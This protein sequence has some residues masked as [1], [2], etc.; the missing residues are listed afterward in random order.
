[1]IEY[2]ASEDSDRDIWVGTFGV[3]SSTEWLGFIS[4]S[5]AS[6]LMVARGMR[7]VETQTGIEEQDADTWGLGVFSTLRLGPHLGP[8]TPFVEAGPGILYTSDEFPPGGT[9]WNFTQRYGFGAAIRLNRNLFLG[10]SF[11]NLHVSNG[12]G[13]G[14]PRNPSFDGT[15]ILVEFRR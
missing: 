13:F 14:H 9:H 12:K 3:D 1:L 4:L 10:I 15:G 7:F 11:R 8:I 6:H 5:G 2:F